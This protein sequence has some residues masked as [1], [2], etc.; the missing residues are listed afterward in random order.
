MFEQDIENS[1]CISLKANYGGYLYRLLDYVITL[2]DTICEVLRNLNT[3]H[4]NTNV[5]HDV[6][7]QCTS[8]QT[9]AVCVVCTHWSLWSIP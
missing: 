6:C 2:Y 9:T 5:D 8:V 4:N 1:D 7:V 3:N